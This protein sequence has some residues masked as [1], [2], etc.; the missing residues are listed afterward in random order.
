MLVCIRQLHTINKIFR[1]Y[2]SRLHEQEASAVAKA[3]K[4]A[5]QTDPAIKRALD[6][7]LSQ[8]K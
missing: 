3:V 7:E 8:N 2:K 6:Q 1:T 5:S 4:M